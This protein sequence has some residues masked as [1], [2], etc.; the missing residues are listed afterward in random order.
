MQLYE[1]LH[2]QFL[3]VQGA[4]HPTASGFGKVPQCQVEAVG[5]SRSQAKSNSENVLPLLAPQ[6]IHYT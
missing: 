3:G 5:I 6:Q 1:L 2:L 4:T